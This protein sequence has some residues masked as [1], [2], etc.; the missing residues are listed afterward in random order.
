MHFVRKQSHA[1]SSNR[2]VAFARA[3]LTYWIT[4]DPT[5]LEPYLS[6][7]TMAA[8]LREAGMGG[9]APRGASRPA[10]GPG[11]GDTDG[12]RARPSLL[13]R[14]RPRRPGEVPGRYPAE[15]RGRRPR[16]A[17]EWP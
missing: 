7:N 10:D 13:P 8:V 6:A 1:E 16:A 9:A 2:L 5:G 3:I 11:G 14:W 4:L 15:Q 12:V 17:G